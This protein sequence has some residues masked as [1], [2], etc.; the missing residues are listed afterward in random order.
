[1][2][3]LKTPESTLKQ[4]SHTASLQRQHQTTQDLSQNRD[5]PQS[6]FCATNTPPPQHS[7]LPCEPQQQTG[8]HQLMY[9]RHVHAQWGHTV[10]NAPDRRQQSCIQGPCCAVLRI[11]PAS[12]PHARR[13]LCAQPSTNTWPVLSAHCWCLK[14][15]AL[16]RHSTTRL[17]I[18]PS[19]MTQ[20]QAATGLA[21]ATDTSR[22]TESRLVSLPT[23]RAGHHLHT[24]H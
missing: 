21:R 10:S 23:T 20:L 12:L 9:M 6:C 14:S 5:N 22:C 3:A 4:R 19:S 24:N 16:L 17:L 11:G 2:V 1:M 15:C 8:Q 7:N 18:A 13:C